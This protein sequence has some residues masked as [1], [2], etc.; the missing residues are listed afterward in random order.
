[1]LDETLAVSLM[2]GLPL[3]RVLAMRGFI[4]EPVAF[5]SLCSQTLLR[6]GKLDRDSVIA[7]IKLVGQNVERL[8]KLKVNPH[9]WAISLRRANSLRLGES[10]IAFRYGKRPA[11]GGCCR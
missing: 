10:F 7:A 4:E 1:M 2:T 11:A 6:D 3:A 5:I 8:A 9:P